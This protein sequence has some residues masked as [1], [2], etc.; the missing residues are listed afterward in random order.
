MPRAPVLVRQAQREDVPAAV[1]VYLRSRHAAGAAI[2]PLVHDDGNVRAW[3]VETVFA[4]RELWIA[5][6]PSAWEP[7][8]W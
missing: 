5:K 1:E 7:I 4:E 3:F 2:P 6:H 8:P